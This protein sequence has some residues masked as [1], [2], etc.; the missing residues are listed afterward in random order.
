MVDWPE[1]IQI[2]PDELVGS[3]GCGVVHA[4]KVFDA[5]N[6]FHNHAGC[7]QALAIFNSRRVYSGF[8]GQSWLLGWMGNRKVANWPIGVTPVLYGAV[9]VCME[10]KIACSVN[11]HCA[12]LPTSR[13]CIEPGLPAV[14]NAASKRCQQAVGGRSFAGSCPPCLASKWWQVE[15]KAPATG[16][17]W[18]GSVAEQL[19][20]MNK[21]GGWLDGAMA[22]EWLYWPRVDQ[23]ILDSEVYCDM[24]GHKHRPCCSFILCCL[25]RAVVWVPGFQLRIVR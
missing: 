13:V 4:R 7:I 14:G 3:D 1:I 25:G 22:R 16:S 2:L 21:R 24:T 11:A 15:Q 17:S 5:G 6:G 18:R 8:A 20:C 23:Q 10:N 9:V 19:E 12:W